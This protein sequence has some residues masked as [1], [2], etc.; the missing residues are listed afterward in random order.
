VLMLAEKIPGGGR[1]QIGLSQPWALSFRSVFFI[2]VRARCNT[3]QLQ[4]ALFNFSAMERATA[5]ILCRSDR[6][7]SRTGYWRSAVRRGMQ[8]DCPNDKRQLAGWV[9]ASIW[10]PVA[11]LRRIICEE[12]KTF[13]L[14]MRFRFTNAQ[15]V[16][17]QK[18][19]LRL[20]L[21]C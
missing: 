17:R 10:F 9:V 18:G 16:S 1:S 5:V 11:A 12:P 20:L 7:S 6:A 21:I 15:A 19:G 13:E 14:P 2:S 8:S 4:P 3:A